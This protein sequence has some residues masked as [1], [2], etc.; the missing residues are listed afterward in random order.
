[1]GRIA[2]L[3]CTTCALLLTAGAAGAA[4]AE[5]DVVPVEGPWH[6]TTTAG[7]PVAFEVSGGQVVNPH[8][9]FRWD[10][11]GSFEQGPAGSAAIEQPSGHW[12]YVGTNGPYVEATFVAP[13]R[14]EG[15]VVAPSRMLPSC[16]ETKAT[17]V[18]EPGAAPFPQAPAVVLVNPQTHK[19][20]TE[21]RKM[22]MKRDGSF[23]FYGLRWEGFG[24]ATATATGRAFLRSGCRRCRD[25]VVRRPRVTLR[26]TELTQQG[27]VRNYLEAHWVFHGPVPPGFRH[28]GQRFFL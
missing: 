6:A 19:L 21:P 23:R 1:M 9:R 4:G 5:A 8:F 14:A 16:P 17:F 25:K 3:M 11:C 22:L 7:L 18:A 28:H 12:K 26:L 2:A 24:E 20:A 10:F 13:D 15:S 27:N